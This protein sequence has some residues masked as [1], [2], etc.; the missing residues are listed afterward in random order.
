MPSATIQ[1]MIFFAKGLIIVIFTLLLLAGILALLGRGKEKSSGKISIKNL[2]KK[3]AKIKE[4]LLA[5]ILPKKSFKKYLK[6]QKADDKTTAILTEKSP[7]KNIFVLR[8][9]GD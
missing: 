2:N 1:L 7:R 4:I 6:N 5:E 9:D 8:F 3:Y